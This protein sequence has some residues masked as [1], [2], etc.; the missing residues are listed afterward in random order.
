MPH[1]PAYAKEA[2]GRRRDG[3]RPVLPTAGVAQK[4]GN[5]HGGAPPQ[6]D[7]RKW[8]WKPAEP[9]TQGF[10]GGLDGFLCVPARLR[11][12]GRFCGDVP[13]PPAYAKGPA[14]GGGIAPARLLSAVGLRKN[15]G[16]PWRCTAQGDGRKWAWKP[17]GTAHTGDF[18]GTFRAPHVCGG[19]KWGLRGRAPSRSLY[20]EGD[21]LRPVF[22]CGRDCA[23]MTTGLAGGLTKPCKGIRPAA[24]TR[25]GLPT[26]APV[27]LDAAQSS[28]LRSLPQVF[29]NSS[30][31]CWKRV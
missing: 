15:G 6:R 27:P 23:I 8:A 1:L 5:T 18:N 7:G 24:L 13:R 11:G 31:V 25:P 3:L 28:S 12:E 14:G 29:L 17:A 20:A 2:C 30:P 10:S 26:H 19:G 4:W 9:P 16:I 21:G 22:A